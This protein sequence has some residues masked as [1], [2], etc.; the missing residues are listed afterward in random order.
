MIVEIGKGVQQG[1]LCPF[2][3][4]GSW[5]G[6]SSYARAM[7]KPGMGKARRQGQMISGLK[8]ETGFRATVHVERHRAVRVHDLPFAVFLA[9]TVR[10]AE[11]ERHF[12]PVR[13]RAGH[14]RQRRGEGDVVACR[15]HQIA[16]FQ[17]GYGRSA[18]SRPKRPSSWSSSATSSRPSMWRCG[19]FPAAAGGRRSSRRAAA[20]RRGCCGCSTARWSVVAAVTGAAFGTGAIR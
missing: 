10:C 12:G 19:D 14:V 4:S 1:L 5:A 15:H 7:S 18:S 13:L 17:A 6:S 11:P 8:A 9:K 2:I 20:S 16:L 3:R